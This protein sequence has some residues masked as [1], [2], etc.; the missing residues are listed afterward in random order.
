M[1]GSVAIAAIAAL[2]TS[3]A[4]AAAQDPILPL[5]E[6]RAGM[7]CT[8]FSVVRGTEPASFDVEIIDVVDG[9]GYTDGP[10]ILFRVSGPAV[11]STGLG[12]GFSGSPIYCDRGDGVPRNVGAISESVGE[13]GGKVALAT[14]IEAVLGV[15]VD[16]PRGTSPRQRRLRDVR[17]LTT[18]LTVTGLAGPLRR[19]L[20]AAAARQGR[21]LLTAPAAPLTPFPVVDLKPGSAVGAGYSSGDLTVSAIGTVSYV[22]EDRVW[23]FGHALDGIG[24][25]S[26]MLQDAYVY[27]VINNPNQDVGA[28][29]KL[30][31]GGHTVGVLSS[32]G[33]SAVAGRKGAAAPSI[34]V[35]AVVTDV[36]RGVTRE[37]NLHAADETDVGM[38]GGASPVS[39]VA[40]LAVG[41]AANAALGGMPQ[42]TRGSGCVELT[43]RELAKPIGFCNRH[44]GSNVDG[45]YFGFSAAPAAGAAEDLFYAL[46]QI[47]SYRFAPPHLTSVKVRVNVRRG[48]YLAYLRQVRFPKRVRPGQRVSVRTVLQ[49]VGGGRETRRYR[50]TVPKRMPPGKHKVNLVGRGSSTG[51]FFGDM[52]MFEGQSARISRAGPRSIKA[53]ANAIGRG[54]NWDGVML[55]GKGVRARAF[56]DSELRL[57]GRVRTT[58][59][60]EGPRRR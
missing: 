44:V 45:G 10:R 38:P 54:R 4:P 9:S 25:R 7:S 39:F 29:Y 17:P 2:L 41:Q 1:R 55:R 35:S 56:R 5:S 27:R 36:D 21:P 51:D 59:R 28:T 57:S 12:P 31:A 50:M 18:P 26:L 49:R 6:V 20:S 52:F 58:L 43:L 47:D 40:P 23:A 46:A 11:D 48:N 16:Q 30:A 33:L 14:P 22:D 24:E 60:V 15:P 53:L 42:R 13:Y 34:P 19:A 37:V 32:D 8:G 3:A